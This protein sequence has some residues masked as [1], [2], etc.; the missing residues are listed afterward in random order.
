MGTSD[1][2]SSDLDCQWLEMTGL[3]NGAR[4]NA[5][6]LFKTQLNDALDV[7]DYSPLN[8]FTEYPIFV[9]CAPQQTEIVSLWK[10]PLDHPHICCS[11][12]GGPHP[13]ACPAPSGGCAGVLPPV[14]GQCAPVVIQ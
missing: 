14:R 9:P 13:V 2:Y 4:L 10:Y 6:Y 3:H 5:W 11:R 8:D 1:N 12:P 7:P